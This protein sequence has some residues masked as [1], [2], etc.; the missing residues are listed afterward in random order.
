MDDMDKEKFLE[1][2]VSYGIIMKGSFEAIEEVKRVLVDID[3]IELIY[4][5]MSLTPLRLIP[6]YSSDSQEES[7]I[8]DM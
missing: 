4:Q 3:G 7:G 1:T 8:D 5:R 2:Q 6:L